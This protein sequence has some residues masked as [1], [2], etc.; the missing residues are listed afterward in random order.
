MRVPANATAA[1]LVCLTAATAW[2]QPPETVAQYT[3]A[4]PLVEFS[5]SRSGRL[6]ARGEQGLVDI[7]DA[8]AHVLVRT[9]AI[10]DLSGD[11]YASAMALSPDGRTLAYADAQGTV[12]LWDVASG[13]LRRTLPQPVGRPERVAWSPNA[14]LIAA[15]GGAV[16]LWDAASGKTLR[17]LPASGDIAFSRDGKLI[18]AVGDDVAKLFDVATGKL[19]KTFSDKSGL[20]PPIAISPDKRFLA[21]GGEDPD[22]VPNIVAALESETAHDLKVKVWDIR[23]GKLLRMLPGRDNQA[24][25][26]VL[27]FS[28]DSRALFSNG[29]G[30]SAFWDVKTGK[31]KRSF[32][33]VGVLSPDGK[34]AATGYDTLVLLDAATGKRLFT[35]P[36]P[37]ARVRGVAFSP[38][39]RLVAAA[40]HALSASGPGGS[41]IWIWDVESGRLLRTLQAEPSQR[42]DVRFLADGRVTSGEQA[43]DVSTGKLVKTWRGPLETGPSA[44]HRVRKWALVSPDASIVV[45]ESEETFPKSLKVWD[46]ATMKLLRT[47]DCGLVMMYRPAFSPDNRYFVTHVGVGPTQLMVLDLRA[48]EQASRLEDS[49]DANYGLLFS[50]DGAEI[51]GSQERGIALWDRDSGRMLLRIP[52]ATGLTFRHLYP[53][54]WEKGRA[55]SLAFAP[56]GRS[57]AAGF[58]GEVRVYDAASGAQIARLQ[59]G[60]EVYMSVAFSP[61]GGRIAAGDE[62]GHVRLWDLKSRRLIHTLI[63]MPR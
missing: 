49:E 31:K 48:G 24:R 35:A 12:Q 33:W 51:A 15:G 50:P 5:F 56:D 43:W 37:P 27:E 44:D 45:S 3:H 61:D 18:T 60:D 53:E 8:R 28:P 4:A 1:F 40:G 9:L 2:G 7:W 21:T 41:G 6:A 62:S 36:P 10:P 19:I 58:V 47:I 59:A 29:T 32:R 34:L 25:S 38:D 20:L 30:S 26:G 16:R 23:T 39:G 63:A 52:P 14:K 57:I 22:W 13:R 55:A 17:T 46:G 11:P 54:G 42:Y